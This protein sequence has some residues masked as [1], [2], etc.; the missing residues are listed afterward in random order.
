MYPRPSFPAPI[1]LGQMSVS[2]QTGSTREGRSRRRRQPSS[3]SRA[4]ADLLPAISSA[5]PS[6]LLIPLQHE[7]RYWAQQQQQHQPLEAAQQDLAEQQQASGQAFS[8]AGAVGPS[9]QA[10]PS[11]STAMASPADRSAPRSAVETGV[12]SY[13]CRSC[14]PPVWLSSNGAL[15]RHRV[16]EH[17][18]HVQVTLRS[19]EGPSV[20]PL[21]SS[22]RLADC[23]VASIHQS[24]ASR[25]TIRAFSAAR[26]ASTT[27]RAPTTYRRTSARRS[28]A[29]AGTKSGPLRSRTSGRR[30][31][32][33]RRRRRR[34]P[35][36]GRLLRARSPRPRSLRPGPEFP[37]PARPAPP[38]RHR[39]PA[40]RCRPSLRTTRTARFRPARSCRRRR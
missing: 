16:N 28:G 4:D 36:P 11:A 35:H 22:K 33:R 6:P 37:A 38:L 26:R 20:T 31:N 29:A 27:A 17:I 30:L 24:T 32:P 21:A 5:C 19:G 7:E 10:T 2:P 3:W 23:L 25:A 9:A 15:R 34:L 13:P 8:V 14:D 1:P 12:H 39:S 18:L 40:P